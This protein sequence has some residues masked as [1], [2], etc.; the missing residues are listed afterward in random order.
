[1]VWATTNIL[2]VFMAMN[3]GFVKPCFENQDFILHIFALTS[4]IS[5][6]NKIPINFFKKMKMKVMNQSV[7]KLFITPKKGIQDLPKNIILFY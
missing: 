3:L 6:C 2:I 1:M 7:C 4:L 5:L